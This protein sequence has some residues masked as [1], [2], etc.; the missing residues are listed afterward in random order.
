MDE[1]FEV[2]IKSKPDQVTLKFSGNLVIN[3]IEDI[4]KEVKE[5]IDLSKPVHFDIANPENIDLTFIQL[6]L[7]VQKTCIN[8]NIGFTVSAKL[9]DDMKLLLTNAGFKSII[10]N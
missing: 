9:K 10:S 7:S 1:P 2:K 8:K 5:S 4:V 6:V 3:Y